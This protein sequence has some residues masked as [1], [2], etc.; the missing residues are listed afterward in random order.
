MNNPNNVLKYFLLYSKDSSQL[1]LS[2]SVHKFFFILFITCCYLYLL[3]NDLVLVSLRLFE[4]DLGN[5]LGNSINTYRNVN[6]LV[7]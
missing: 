7:E 2:K 4:N 5:R 1:T 3:S 6:R